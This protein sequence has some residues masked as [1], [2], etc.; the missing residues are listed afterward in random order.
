MGQYNNIK[1]F[2]IPTVTPFADSSLNNKKNKKDVFVI[3]WRVPDVVYNGVLRLSF[4]LHSG[5]PSLLQ[6]EPHP[7]VVDGIPQ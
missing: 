5:L 6:R 1:Y 3:F 7:G 2:L 4:D